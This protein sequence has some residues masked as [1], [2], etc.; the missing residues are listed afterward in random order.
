M[1]TSRFG[2]VL[3]PLI[4]PFTKDFALNLDRIHDEVDFLI[5]NDRCDS[6][7]IAG[8][9]GEF[10]ALRHDE[11]VQLFKT[12]KEAAKGRLP[13]IAGTGAND[14]RE[15]IDLSR[16]AEALGY[17]ALMILPPYFGNPTQ[18]EIEDHFR[19]IAEAVSLPILLYNIPLFT[20]VNIRPSTTSKLAQDRQFIGIKEE[21]GINPL[22]STDTLLCTP[23]DFVVYCGDDV[24]TLQVVIQGGSGVVSGGS[25]IVGD[26]M[27]EQIAS[28]LSGNVARAHEIYLR[29]YPFFKSLV[30]GERVNPVPLTK[31]A[32]RLAGLDAGD[33]RP[34]LRPASEAE[35]EGLRATMMD[36]GR[37]AV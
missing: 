17:D 24:M 6:L 12:A 20:G 11:R 9:N 2:K 4:T 22:Q 10:Y 15:V 7:I 30:P 37:V 34:P 19:Q 1:R 27:K 31:A 26:L 29:T 28:L 35:T 13:L 32:L 25:H 33:P 14:T 8:T 23:D 21:A 36:L 16:E 3:I 18:D 5:E